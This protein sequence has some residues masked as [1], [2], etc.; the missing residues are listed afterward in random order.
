MAL[1]CEAVDDLDDS[2]VDAFLTMVGALTTRLVF[3]VP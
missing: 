1:G 2:A 3:P